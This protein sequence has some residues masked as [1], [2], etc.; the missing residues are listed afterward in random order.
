MVRELVLPV[1]HSPLV[2][3]RRAQLIV[4]RVRWI[5]ATFAV[6]TP[7]WI[8]V[9]L[10]LFP[11]PLRQWLVVL[12]ILATLA[13]ALIALGFRN[14]ERIGV[15]FRALAALVT[16]P[17]VFF[18]VSDVLISGYVF[19]G[20]QL[21]LSGGYAFLPFVMVAGLSVFPITAVESV[22]FALPLVL[23][24]VA[25]AFGDLDII[26]FTSSLGA[27]WL[28]SLLMVVALLSGMS[29]LHFM[30]QLVQQASHDVLTRAYTRRVGE[31]LLNVQFTNAQR[32]N[33]PMAVAFIDLDDFKTIN[34]VYG[35]EEGDNSLRKAADAM[36]KI[37]RRG[38]IVVRWGGEEFL[39]IMPN[40]TPPGALIA[41]ARLRKEGLGE[42]PDG[43]RQT[44]SI[45]VAE[46]VSD[47][48]ETW[49]DLVEKADH[50]M[51]LAKKSGKNRIVTV[52]E[53]AAA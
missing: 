27:L 19:E 25:A 2:E 21:A 28:L 33:Q 3:R 51:Y 52:D 49:A 10:V 43:R 46:R 11:T 34:D 15:A 36:R 8:I 30:M 17:V 1:G 47:G 5:A 35:H 38:D 22:I 29:Q 7:L 53:D 23:A 44:A 40:T 31:E 37:L 13:F 20:L 41:L 45:G 4:S 24:V 26:P 32:Q 42:R 9:D 48:L 12:R 18:L 50:R 14:T 6:L 16:V 39:I